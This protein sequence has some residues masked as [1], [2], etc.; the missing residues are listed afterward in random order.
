MLRPIAVS[1]VIYRPWQIRDTI[2]WLPSKWPFL[3]KS[4][5][6]GVSSYSETFIRTKVK[7]YFVFLRMRE[8]A[9]K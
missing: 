9:R 1:P 2:R 4:P 6:M 3:G 7:K 8:A 5:L